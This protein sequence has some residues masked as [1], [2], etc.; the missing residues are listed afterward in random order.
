MN[1]KQVQDK[2]IK[3]VDCGQIFVF[4]ANEQRYYA[5]RQLSEP[6]R[7]KECRDKKRR[8]REA[9]DRRENRNY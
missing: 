3:C 7:C 8:E 4:E 6:K 1:D 5:E 9:R 2:E